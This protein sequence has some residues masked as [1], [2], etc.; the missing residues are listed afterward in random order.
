MKYLIVIA[1]LLVCAHVTTATIAEDKK[2]AGP[3]AEPKVWV[4]EHSGQFKGETVKYTT[5]TGETYL[6]NADGKPIASIFST[7]YV[8]QG[9]KDP[10]TR[11]IAFFYNGGP[12]SASLWLHMGAWG[13]KRVA[14]PSDAKDDSAP[15]YPLIDNEEA[16]LDVIDMVFIDP[17]GTGFSRVI[18]EGKKEDFYGVTEDAR[19][20]AQ[21]I[22]LWLS[23]NGR[24]NS[25]KYIGGESYG[26]TRSAAI[27]N[28]LEGRFNDVA[29]NG[30]ILVST[31]LD[32]SARD[33][34][35]GNEMGYILALPTMAATARYHG[36]AGQGT[37]VEDFVDAARNF[38]RTDYALALLK[39]NSLGDQERNSVRARLAH[40]TG[41]KESYLDRADL[42]V[43]P[44]RFY[45]ELLR[46]EGK[47]VG[48]LDSRYTGTD[49]DSA[50]DSVDNDPSFYGIDASYT[51]AINSYLRE[52]LGVDFER[53]YS[54]IGGLGGSWNWKLSERGRNAYL[55]V[56]PYLGRALRENSGL[57]I[58]NAAGY[59]D[60]ATP[61]Y[62]AEYSLTRTGFDPSRIDFK[63]YEA[64]HMMYVREADLIKLN[65]DIREFIK[66]R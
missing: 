53:Q 13:P 62:G 1:Q 34:T 65:D 61:L 50:G 20:I 38:A 40:F 49:Y 43:T 54:V 59:Y 55:N 58:F 33:T 36:K 52:D 15:P 60:F 16:L 51:A 22:R 41:L 30:I 28:E 66:N 9:V 10:S 2:A 25:P 29:L 4:S 26:T 12:G 57:R 63:Y 27:V 8:K 48:R 24:W 56:A 6:K 11:P 3:I 23:E 39:G 14:I 47:T 37:T 64:G 46:D 42:R 7:A 32:F 21:F 18:G 45:K 31:I 19:S 5:T 44:G 17:V 35:Q